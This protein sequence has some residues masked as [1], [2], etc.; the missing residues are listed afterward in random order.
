M[1]PTDFATIRP[2][3][4]EAPYF[5]EPFTHLWFVTAGTTTEN[6]LRIGVISKDIGGFYSALGDPVLDDIY[7]QYRSEVDP[8]KR[9]DLAGSAVRLIYDTFAVLPIATTDMIWGKGPRIASW[10]PT[11]GSIAAVNFETLRP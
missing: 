11:N 2:T 4:L 6:A 8:G 3:F 9:A 7:G 10:S 1:R 5:T